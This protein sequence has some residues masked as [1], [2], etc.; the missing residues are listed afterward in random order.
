M[1]TLFSII[2]REVPW[3]EEPGGLQSMGSQGV[4]HDRSDLALEQEM[5]AWSPRSQALPVSHGRSGRWVLKGQQ[6]LSVLH[7]L[8]SNVAGPGS[9]SNLPLPQPPSPAWI[10]HLSHVY[11]GWPT[12]SASRSHGWRA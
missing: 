9:W 6:A 12:K 4:G 3:A 2:A 11:C 1:A 5:R 10:L 7:T 8:A